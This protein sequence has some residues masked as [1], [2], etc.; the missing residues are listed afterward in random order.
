MRKRRYVVAIILFA[1]WAGPGVAAEELD[2]WV[3][4][5]GPNTGF[6]LYTESGELQVTLANNLGQAEGHI[7]APD[8][9]DSNH[10]HGTLRGKKEPAKDPCGHGRVEKNITALAE[11]VAVAFEIELAAFD[12]LA[13]DQPNFATARDRCADAKDPLVQA[14][15]ALEKRF[16]QGDVDAETVRAINEQLEAAMRKD[17]KCQEASDAEQLR[18]AKRAV[19][20]GIEHKQTALKKIVKAKLFLD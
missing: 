5:D 6:S 7:G 14:E 11:H 16:K 17:E 20:T 10:F 13:D 12:A 1:V 18:K 4:F 9:C 2:R 3:F 8:K 15:L 19:R